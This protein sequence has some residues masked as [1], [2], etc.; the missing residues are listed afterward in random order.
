[1]SG[2]QI[3][4]MNIS[5]KIDFDGG[6]IIS[7]E[8]P[9]RA[10]LM[11][12]EILRWKPSHI[13]MIGQNGAKVAK[14]D[15]ESIRLH[16]IVVCDRFEMTE[17]NRPF[18]DHSILLA[19][20]QEGFDYAHLIGSLDDGLWFAIFGE[21]FAINTHANMILEMLVNTFFD[22]KGGLCRSDESASNVL[23]LIG[24]SGDRMMAGYIQGRQNSFGFLTDPFGPNVAMRNAL[25]GTN[26]FLCAKSGG[27][28]LC[29]VTAEDIVDFLTDENPNRV[30]L[31]SYVQLGCNIEDIA[32]VDGARD[33]MILT[34][35][36][37][38]YR[39]LPSYVRFN[40]EGKMRLVA[41]P[42]DGV[43]TDDLSGDILS[44][45][46]RITKEGMLIFADRTQGASSVRFDHAQSFGSKVQ[47]MIT[48]SLK[49]GLTMN[50]PSS[51]VW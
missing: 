12:V 26:V 40:N 15:P 21:D 19:L 2:L 32:I 22:E 37:G 11:H 47:S 39:L 9:M 38:K 6:Q 4:G 10:V 44:P 7:V 45:I 16:L 43:R 46:V 28:Q 14:D 13:V 24:K 1:M 42:I 17:Q 36:D 30:L 8:G 5:P 48:N 50:H 31:W 3:H 25:V 33:I 27:K 35:I 20:T 41:C 18:I 29:G 51:G 34:L 23:L 49:G